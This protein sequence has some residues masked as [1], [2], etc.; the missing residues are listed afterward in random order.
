MCNWLSSR[1]SYIAGTMRSHNF[2]VDNKYNLYDL[3]LKKIKFIS[4]FKI[5]DQ[6]QVDLF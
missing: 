3:Y 5:S 2:A 1:L 6:T 4:L